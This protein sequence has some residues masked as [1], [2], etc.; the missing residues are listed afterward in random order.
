MGLEAAAAAAKNGLWLKGGR[1]EGEDDVAA[2]AAAAAA[3]TAVDG[4]N[5]RSRPG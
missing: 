3:A 4:G 1:P 2:A 5:I